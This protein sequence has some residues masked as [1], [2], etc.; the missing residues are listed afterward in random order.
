MQKV[1]L[2]LTDQEKDLLALKGASLGYGVTKFI[3]FLISREALSVMEDIPTFQLSAKAERRALE[4]LKE[5]QA[6][7]SKELKRAG[8]L[9]SL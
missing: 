5:Y 9:D 4:A 6:G 3:K 8:E 1:Q 2:T 7:K